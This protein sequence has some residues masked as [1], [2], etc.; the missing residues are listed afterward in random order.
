[1]CMSMRLLEMENSKRIICLKSVLLSLKSCLCGIML[2]FL[3]VWSPTMLYAQYFRNLNVADGL[4]NSIGKCFAQD[5]QGFVWVGTF[6]GLA[7]YDGFRFTTYRHVEGDEN[8]LADSH[9]ESLCY[10][11]KNGLWVGTKNGI[12]YL[13]LVD[14]NI[15]HCRYR[16]VLS[17]TDKKMPVGCNIWQIIQSGTSFWAVNELGQLFYKRTDNTFVWHRLAFGKEKVKAVTDYDGTHL[18]VLSQDKLRLVDNKNFKVVAICQM[19]TI[20]ES[21]I[22]N[23]YYSRN[24][25]LAFVGFGYGTSGKA[26]SVYPLGHQ[27]SG[28]FVIKQVELPLPYHIK[29]VRDYA[30]MTLFATDGQG[31]KVMKNGILVQDWIPRHDQIAGNAIHA[32]F[33]DRS[34][35]LWMGTYREGICLY[36]HRFDYFRSLTKSDGLLSYNVVSAISADASKIYIGTD[37]GGL[38][39]YDRATSHSY[40]LTPNNSSLPGSNVVAVLNDG[41][42]L[43]MGIYGKGICVLN[44]QTGAI[45]TLDLPAEKNERALNLYTMWQIVDDH[46]GHLLFRGK[47]LYLYDKQ[48]QQ[49]SLFPLSFARKNIQIAVDDK[50]LW[51]VDAKNLIQVNL[52][53]YKQKRSYTLPSK[54][55]VNSLCVQGKRVFLSERNGDFWEM[56]LKDGSWKEI[57]N[58]VLGDKEVESIQPDGLGKLWLGTDNGLLQYNLRTGIT[59]LYGKENHLLQSQFCANA[60]FFDGSTIYFGSTNG[61]ISFKPQQLNQKFA[62]N[63]VYFDDIFLLG[64][65]EHLALWG[66]K[67][68]PLDFSYDQ[69]FF[70]IRFSVPELVTPHKLKFRYKLE[71]LDN[72]WREVEDVRE[73]SYTNV[74]PGKYK[75][76]IQATNG[77]GRWS[78]QMS[79]LV[80]HVAH[81]WYATWWARILWLLIII[82]VIYAIFRHYAEKEQ[83]KHE[84]AQKEQEKQY[85][86]ARKEQEKE[87][88]LAQ[89]E[90]E[91]QMIKK[92][93]EDK[94]NFFANITHELRTPMFLITAPLEELLSS[95]QR[96]VQV[97]YSY[98]R[99]MYRNAVR[100]NRLVSS[101]LDLRKME[102]GSLRLKVTRRDVVMVCKRLSVDYRALCLQKNIS[103][104]FETSL[105]SLVADV[106]IEKLELILSNLIAN[107]YKYTNE[108]GKVTLRL[109]SEAGKM[110]FIVSDT[111]IGI[112]KENQDKVF[113]RY[114]R[115][116]ENS[117]A[118]GD[119]LGL[120]FVKNLVELHHGSISLES[121]EGKGST[122]TV[123][124]PLLQPKEAKE[125]RNLPVIEGDLQMDAVDEIE[126]EIDEIGDAY[127]SPTATQSILIIDDERET[128]LLLQRY[129]GKDY[130][131]FKAG[132]GEEGLQVAADVMPDL[133]ICDVMMPKMD[134]FEFLGKFKDDKKLQHIPVIMFTAKILDED[135]IVA[136]RYG[137]DAYLTKP[138]SLKFLKARIESFLKPKQV[139]LAENSLVA[140]KP[141]SGTTKEDQKFILQCR[142]IIDKNMHRDDFNVDFLASELGMSHSSL[143]K[144]VKAITGKSVVD[145]IVGCR[146]FRAVELFHSGVTSMTTVADKC[147]FSDLHS[148]RASF[149]SRMGMSPKQFVQQM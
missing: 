27:A 12:D 84:I 43:W 24:Q 133:V 67:P 61:L 23:L 51:V 80:I 55:S 25:H 60:A 73:V 138:V 50:S 96:P 66:D 111:G 89:K 149:K 26:F 53:D 87:H 98:L 88:E 65:H 11:G 104:Q 46:H 39:I 58:D 64:T 54:V 147:G 36:S 72:E 93:N 97:P 33:E 48:T 81:P 101:I 69:N 62:D 6:N 49:V 9:V 128:V 136:F 1:M 121:E 30:D 32:L 31:L 119:G 85:E 29:A 45:K 77:D 114:Y 8:T 109:V 140:M 116:D 135:K 141:K 137:A 100:L 94:L 20:D 115:V 52:S 131:I 125:E 103:F 113:E 28:H 19:P 5:G 68:A 110:N 59:K 95:S 134:G 124:M 146:I 78:G 10:T 118:V 130:K 40:S 38:N 74:S 37:G 13:S 117:K 82:G 91:K 102:V 144:K 106:D 122:F 108:G 70:T 129:L 83:M 42:S 57:A 63:K 14:K 145:M 75:F 99:G 21:Y 16:D 4:P 132:D 44:K 2:L 34:H 139:G 120:S 56:N 126:M 35:T 22:C 76:V 123:T 47:K 18:L 142:E 7:R 3:L 17:K 112:A 90:L 127:Q 92:N 41:N 86:I 71:G 143:Y 148:F 105:E 79:E 107:A 15:T